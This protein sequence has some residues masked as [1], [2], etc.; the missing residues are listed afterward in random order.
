MSDLK[1]SLVCPVHN[2]SQYLPY[3]LASLKDIENEVDE[4]IFVLDNCTDDSKKLIDQHLPD[5]KIYELSKH[6]WKFYAAESFQHG[7]NQAKCEIVLAVGADLI[8]DSRIPFIIQQVFA[9]KKV[10]MVCFRYLNYSLF[11]TLLRIHGEYNNL[12]MTI[13]QRLRKETRHMGVYAFRQQMMLEIGSLSDIISEY[14]EYCRR[15]KQEGWEVVY[16]PFTQTLHLRPGVTS[17]KQFMQGVARY[18]LPSYTLTKT[19][20]HSFIHVKPHLIVGYLHAKR[21]GLE[22]AGT[23]R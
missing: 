14:D 16:I 21:Y 1:I 6:L 7:F 13:L 15:S 19:V 23:L 20:F 12:Y 11:S 18:Y 22:V 10:G 5:A 9:D 4:K 2:E 17:E 3:F 8:L